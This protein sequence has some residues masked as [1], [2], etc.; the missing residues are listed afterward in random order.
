MKGRYRRKANHDWWKRL[1]EARSR[2][3][4]EWHWSKGHAGHVIQEA[5]DRAARKIAALG[6]VEPSVLQDAVELFEGPIVVGLTATPPDFEEHPAA[7]VERYQRLFG[8][9]DYEMP[10][11]AVVK[12]GFIAPYQDLAY[13]VRPT[14]AELAYVAKADA[15]LHALVEDFCQAAPT[16]AAGTTARQNLVDWV[17]TVLATRQLAASHAKDWRTFEQRDSTFAHAAR[18]VD[19]ELRKS[20]AREVPLEL[21]HQAKPG[22]DGRAKVGRAAHGIGLQEVIRAHALANHSRRPSPAMGV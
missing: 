13:F 19:D 12:D 9:L 3:S 8:D 5:A 11:P 22:V 17:C 20:D 16:G 1:D 7:D 2:H 18:R 6:H 21:A 15:A 10:V 4:V 14:A